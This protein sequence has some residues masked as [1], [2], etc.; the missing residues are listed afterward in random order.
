MAN[1]LL[2]HSH[3]MVGGILGGAPAAD[4]ARVH[5][6]GDFHQRAVADLV[7]FADLPGI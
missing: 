6:H 5:A 4:C 7:D 1:K 2:K 3:V